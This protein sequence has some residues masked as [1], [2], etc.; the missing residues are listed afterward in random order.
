[1][2]SSSGDTSEE[3][4]YTLA[5]FWV[6]PKNWFWENAWYSEAAKEYY[7]KNVVEPALKEM[8]KKEKSDMINWKIK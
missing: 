8:E 7:R 5:S 3:D 1:M 4:P 2:R 6:K